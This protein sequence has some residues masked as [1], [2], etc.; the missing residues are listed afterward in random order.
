MVKKKI[1]RKQK[2]KIKKS[3]YAVYSYD[4]IMR[5]PKQNLDRFGE[6]IRLS[7]SERME[8]VKHRMRLEQ[9]MPYLNKNQRLK[10]VKWGRGPNPNF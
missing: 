1:T 6:P 4:R 2:K 7:H 8:M 3:A 5:K 9:I 10:L